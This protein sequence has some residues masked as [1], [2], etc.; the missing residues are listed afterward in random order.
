MSA[1]VRIASNKI[2]ELAKLNV[3]A[4]LGVCVQ[5]CKPGLWQPNVHSRFIQRNEWKLMLL[6]QQDTQ[7]PPA[8]KG[9]QT[10]HVEQIFRW[11]VVFYSL[12]RFNF[13][14][15]F[16]VWHVQKKSLH[17]SG[18]WWGCC[19]SPWSQV[20]IIHFGEHGSLPI[21]PRGP[22]TMLFSRCLY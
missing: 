7:Q 20:H 1:W 21:I 17:E 19:T 13:F 22:Q 18:P 8:N 14:I 12:L 15:H 6:I 3:A 9:Q 5:C 4:G 2:S 16:Q 11:V 10:C